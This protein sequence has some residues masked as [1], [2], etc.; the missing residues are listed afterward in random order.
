M[1]SRLCSVGGIF[2]ELLFYVKPLKNKKID[3]ALL[4]VGVDECKPRFFSKASGQLEWSWFKM[5][6]G[7]GYKDLI[8]GIAVNNKLTSAYISSVN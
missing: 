4:H 1:D 8:S 6:I 3:A 2:K 7:W 5:Q